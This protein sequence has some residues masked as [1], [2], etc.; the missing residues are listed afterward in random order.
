[1]WVTLYTKPDCCLCDEARGAIERVRQEREFEL[2]EVDITRD[3]ALSETYG[4]RVPVVA[5][6]G[7]PLFELAVDE[8]EFRR[9]TALAAETVT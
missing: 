2:E 5:L 7:R 3:R 6:D 9:A 1:L 4:E 8:D